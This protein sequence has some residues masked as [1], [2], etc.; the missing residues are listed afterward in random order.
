[1]ELRVMR[2]EGTLKIPCAITATNVSVRFRD[3]LDS[4]PSSSSSSVL[5]LLDFLLSVPFSFKDWSSFRSLGIGLWSTFVCVSSCE[6]GNWHNSFP[7]SLSG[8]RNALVSRPLP[9]WRLEWTVNMLKRL[10]LYSEDLLSAKVWLRTQ[11]VGLLLTNCELCMCRRLYG[12]T[13]FLIR[14][15]RI[16]GL[17]RGLGNTKRTDALLICIWNSPRKYSFIPCG[18]EFC[19]KNFSS[20]LLHPQH[21]VVENV[22]ALCTLGN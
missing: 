5:L 18:V 1:M 7:S 14:L 13:S 12:S 17:S 15:C 10:K 4:G 19:P 11:L 22:A 9:S 21:R 16:D 6:R 20:T 2:L 8:N 3:S